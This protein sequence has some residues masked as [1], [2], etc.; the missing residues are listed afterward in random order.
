MK[1]FRTLLIAAV[2]FIGANQAMTAQAKTAHIDVTELMTNMPD[3]KKAQGELQK[4]GEN[5][6]KQY[7]QM[8]SEF[9]TKMQKYDSEQK[10]VSDAVNETRMKEMQEMQSRVQAFQQEAQKQL[11]TKREELLRPAM[12]KAQ[13]AI[14]K[15]AKAKGYQYVLDS[16]VGSGVIYADGPN[17]LADVKKELGF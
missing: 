10:T 9:Q 8:A 15:V 16:T 11:E 5:Y 1:Q 2:M 12:E 17:L 3:M 4:L 7:Q 14:K 6:D 13:A